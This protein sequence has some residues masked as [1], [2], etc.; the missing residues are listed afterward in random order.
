MF[1]S[2]RSSTQAQRI[3]YFATLL[4]VTVPFY[5][6]PLLSE[7][8]N[9]VEA[10]VVSNDVVVAAFGWVSWLVV[11]ISLVVKLPLTLT[12]ARIGV[13]GAFALCVW[14][15]VIVEPLAWWAVGGS[16]AMVL[17]VLAPGV[18]DLFI[19]GASY[20]DERRFALRVPLP[21]LLLLVPVWAVVVVGVL[22]GPVVC[23]YHG[24][25]WG[26][27]GLVLGL[28][29][30]FLGF[31]ALYRL[32]DRFIVFV[33]NGLVLHDRTVLTEPVLLPRRDIVGIMPAKATTNATDLTATAL[34]LALEIRLRSEF[35]LPLVRSKSST[36]ER[37]VQNL[38]IS[39][40]RPA[41]VM[42]TAH[43]RGFSTT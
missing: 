32:S 8:Q 25:L 39:P 9:V 6:A 30:A 42:H 34:G 36:E 43:Q 28:P 27:V 12:V 2:L 11:T 35:K 24:Y 4:W 31:N 18:A 23:L 33:P 14:A 40:T 7:A 26:L 19:N 10:Q 38:L 13:V 20:G 21:V 1:D 16:F 41:D 5:V 29:S 3:I 17:L 37:A 22:S 15:A